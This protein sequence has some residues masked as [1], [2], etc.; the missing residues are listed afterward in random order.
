[1]NILEKTK[2]IIAKHNV[3]ANSLSFNPFKVR[4]EPKSGE[5][6]W[7]GDGVIGINNFLQF[8]GS[9]EK[10]TDLQI[11]Y[12]NRIPDGW[13]GFDVSC[14]PINWLNALEEFLAELE[15]DSPDFEIHQIKLKIGTARI[16]I[17]K[18]SKE[19]YDSISLLEEVMQDNNLI[20]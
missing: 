15:K 9:Y 1:M 3:V 14:W 10:E 20:Y 18:V 16:H 8:Q 4:R 7:A 12:F 6:G 5:Q 11:R 13:Y 19:A 17:N 2:E